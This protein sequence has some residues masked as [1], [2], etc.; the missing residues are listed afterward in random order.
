MS[1]AN[2]ALTPR[3]RLGLARLIVDEGWPVATAA[4]YFHVSWPTVQ[5]WAQRYTAMGA[6]GMADRSSRPHRCPNRT[7]EPVKRKI[8]HLR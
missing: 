4:R 3:A 6:A 8:V 2:A 5:R 7:P 1:H